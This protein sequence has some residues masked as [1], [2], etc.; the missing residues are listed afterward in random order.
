MYLIQTVALLMVFFYTVDSD[1]YTQQDKR[2]VFDIIMN[3]DQDNI[4]DQHFEISKYATIL[5]KVTEDGKSIKYPKFRSIFLTTKPK[6]RAHILIYELKR[7]EMK[8]LF[9]KAI[10]SRNKTRFNEGRQKNVLV[11]F[12]RIM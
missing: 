1:K 7:K 4:K 2:S 10:K 12:I 11:N 6:H 9:L 8:K 3:T 5:S